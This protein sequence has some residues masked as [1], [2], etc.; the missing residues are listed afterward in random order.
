VYQVVCVALEQ[1]I[2]SALAENLTAWKTV[3]FMKARAARG[4]RRKFKAAMSKVAEAEPDES[5]RIL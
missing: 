1:F 4:G 2:A 3:E 5:D